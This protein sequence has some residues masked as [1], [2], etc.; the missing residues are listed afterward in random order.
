MD[1]EIKT[2]LYDVLQSIIE[3]ERFFEDKPKKFEVYSKDIKTKSA[4]ERD[5]EIIGEV[6]K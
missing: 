2:W 4:V 6:P 3:I 5:V 1:R